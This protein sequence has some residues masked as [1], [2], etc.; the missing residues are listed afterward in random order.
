MV[1]GSMATLRPDNWGELQEALFV[2]ACDPTLGRHRSPYAFRGF[3]DTSHRLETTLIR[4]GGNFENLERHLLRNLFRKY[5]HRDVVE[6]DSL[7]HWLS[8]AQHHRLPTR[9]MD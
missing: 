6:R 8:L 9:L 3:S 5:A 1:S 7:W 2:D 4:L